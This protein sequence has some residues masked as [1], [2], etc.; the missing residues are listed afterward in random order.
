MKTSKL[1]IALYAA[2]AIVAGGLLANAQRE[3]PQP[4]PAP[5]EPPRNEVSIVVEPAKTIEPITKFEPVAPAQVPTPE[6]AVTPR[7]PPSTPAPVVAPS[8]TWKTYLPLARAEA[9]R[10]NKRLLIY[11]T[12]DWCIVCKDMERTLFP[13]EEVA[14]LLSQFA[15]VKLNA[16]ADWP[17]GGTV[18]DKLG[19]SK[20]PYYV[21][22]APDGAVTFQ[23]HVPPANF[24]SF[25]EKQK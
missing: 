2:M 12:A 10:D 18:A 9:V 4:T 1:D 24:L 17:G 7:Q 25:L 20:L 13:R 23:G 11:V 21:I 22:T 8:V 3:E 16:E 19:A 14:N 5:P 6:P 15:C